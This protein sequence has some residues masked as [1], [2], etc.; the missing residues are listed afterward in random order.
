M[1]GVIVASGQ[2]V[3]LD[4]I[5]ECVGRRGTRVDSLPGL[6]D[7]LHD[8]LPDFFELLQEIEAQRVNEPVQGWVAL[9]QAWPCLVSPPLFQ[10]APHRVIVTWKGG[11]QFA[12]EAPL[13][14]RPAS[15][16]SDRS[17][18]AGTCW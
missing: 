17:V 14:S 12:G 4:H 11:F 16:T 9:L 7:Q 5:G 15:C 10:C 1:G 3:G 13:S 18:M 6:P 8:V 2:L